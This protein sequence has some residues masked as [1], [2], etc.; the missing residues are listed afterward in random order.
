[1]YLDRRELLLIMA[2]TARRIL[3][4]CE[5]PPG[6]RRR[7]TALPNIFTFAKYCHAYTS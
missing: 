4:V 2:S 7:A 6:I 5:E 1:M 3:R